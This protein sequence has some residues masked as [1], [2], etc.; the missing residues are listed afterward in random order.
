MVPDAGLVGERGQISTIANKSTL[1]KAHL[2]N[3]GEA[4]LPATALG[5]PT[6]ILAIAKFRLLS[7][8]V[9]GPLF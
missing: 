2:D 8:S 3:A 4:V 1:F 6:A 5:V 9:N 7:S